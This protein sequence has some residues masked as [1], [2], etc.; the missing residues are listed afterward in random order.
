MRSDAIAARSDGPRTG[1]PRNGD[2]NGLAR[3]RLMQ[4]GDQVTFRDTNVRAGRCR[5][6]VPRCVVGGPCYRPRDAQLRCAAITAK[7]SVA[8]ADPRERDWYERIRL[9]PADLG[10]RRERQ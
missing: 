4:R 2:Q 3:E 7:P 9:Q 1:G 10:E 6:V 5:R 8:V